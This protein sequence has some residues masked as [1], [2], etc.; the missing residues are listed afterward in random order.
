M[1]GLMLVLLKGSSLGTPYPLLPS[2]RCG[3]RFVLNNKL[4]GSIPWT[5]MRNGRGTK[6]N[7]F[8]GR[9]PP[10]NTVVIGCCFL[11]DSQTFYKC[12]TG[13][14]RAEFDHVVL[15]LCRCHGGFFRFI[16]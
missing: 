16:H 4:A 9:V 5:L 1:L 11:T 10:A 3:G 14:F 12:L 13:I 6:V 8:T 7:S 15:N 2:R